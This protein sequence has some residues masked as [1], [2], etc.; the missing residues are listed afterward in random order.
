M[1]YGHG[2]TGRKLPDVSSNRSAGHRPAQSWPPPAKF[3]CCPRNW[4]PNVARD[5]IGAQTPIAPCNL[6][7]PPLPHVLLERFAERR[8]RRLVLATLQYETFAFTECRAWSTSY[9]RMGPPARA[10]RPASLKA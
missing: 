6:A 2:A 3:A 4:N 8:E 10:K 9:A 1:D 5:D 7:S